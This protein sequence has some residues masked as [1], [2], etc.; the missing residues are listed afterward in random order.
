MND[1]I[2]TKL[3]DWQDILHINKTFL[4]PFIFRGQKNEEWELETSIERLIKHIDNPI[5]NAHY[6]IAERWMLSEFIRKFR[7][8]NNTN[9]DK[10]NY[11]EWLSIMQHYG[12]PTRLLDFTASIFIAIFFAVVE[13]E[14]DS[15]IWCVNKKILESNLVDNYKL[16]YKK[17]EALKDEINLHHINFAQKFIAKELSYSKNY[18]NTVVP[19]EPFIINERLARQQGLF[20]MPTNPNFTFLENLKNAFNNKEQNFEKK[21][22][23]EL[24]NISDEE[25]KEYSNN[26]MIEIIKMSLLK[27]DNKESI[28]NLTKGKTKIIKIII[29]KKLKKPILD[30]LKHMN[31]TA[32]ILFPGLEGLAKSLLHT[33]EVY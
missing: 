32:E 5:C 4:H 21:T 12:A 1:F 7:L 33:Q 23:E 11:I 19:I 26:A 9:I 15:A 29:P 31:I 6:N 22:I 16:P 17:L 2:E 8:Y 27:I 30:N 24:I 20:L 10:D 3:N 28:I 13:S 25:S 18:P 14:G